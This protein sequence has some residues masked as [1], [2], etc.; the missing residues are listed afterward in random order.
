MR[1]I[2]QLLLWVV[3]I[4]LGYLTFNAIYQPVQFNKVKEKRYAKVIENLKDIRAAELAHKKVTGEF[5]G[6]FDRLVQFIDTAEFALTQRRDTTFLDEEYRKTYGVDQYVEDVVVDTLGFVSV[7]DSL[8]KGNRERYA[9]MMN[10]PIEGV[11]A[12]FELD[13]GHVMKKDS[14]IPVFEARVA[15]SVILADQDKNLVA[16]ENQIQ[17]VDGVNGAYIQIGSMEEVN[18]SGNWPQIYGESDD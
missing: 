4:F 17:S 12:Q 7:K 2:I 13:A 8:F 18:T 15:K 3:I 6:D 10:I 14:R 9:N 11:D 16:Q 5:Q 1:L